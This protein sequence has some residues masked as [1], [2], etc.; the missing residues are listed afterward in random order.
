LNASLLTQHATLSIPTARVFAPLLEPARYKGAWGGRG[1]GKSQFFAG[2]AVETAVLRPGLRGLCVREIQNSLKDSSKRLIEDKIAEHGLGSEFRIFNDRVETP[3][4]G[5]FVFVGMQDHTADSIKSYEGFDFAWVEEAQNLSLRSL[6]KLRPTL[7]K[8]GSELWC[9]WNPSRKTDAIDEFLRGKQ[10]QG[11][12]VVKSNWRDNPWFPEVLNQERLTDLEKY[13]DLYEHVWEGAYATA[14]EG[15]YFAKAL[16]QARGEQRIGFV[17]KDP[18]SPVKVY[19]DIGG[20]S[21]KSDAF[22]MWV[23]Q[24]VGLQIRVLDHYEAVGQEFGEHVHWLRSRGYE[25]ALVRLPHDGLKH[26]M[27]HRVTPEGYFRQAGFSVSTMANI[28]P[29]AASARIEAV[30]RVL[31]QCWF[32]AETTQA[33]LE[34]LGFY[35]EKR[36]DDRQVGLGPEHDWSS[37]SAD[38]FGQMALDYQSPSS[39]ARVKSITTNRRY[40]V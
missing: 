23:V 10:P 17:P 19:C 22:A 34:A 32:N 27:V 8:P 33:G 1:S 38:A 20:T 28:G 26:D 37:H 2:L 31:P 30:R 14:I 6:T 21:A 3:G 11:S 36:A 25:R 16:A 40:I 18:L 35:H 5:V 24:T 29:G 12:I 15:A 39:T 13:P 9:S 7:R 4:G